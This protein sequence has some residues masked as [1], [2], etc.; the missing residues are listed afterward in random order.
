M[1]G[2]VILCICEKDPIQWPSQLVRKKIDVN[3]HE[4]LYIITLKYQFK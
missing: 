1:Q 3:E 4:R 2:E